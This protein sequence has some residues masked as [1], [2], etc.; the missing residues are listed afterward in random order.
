[1][2]V[3]VRA[4]DALAGPRM[5]ALRGLDDREVQHLRRVRR[6][7]RSDQLA[8]CLCNRPIAFVSCVLVDQAAR[9]EAWRMRVMSSLVLALAAAASVFPVWRRSWKRSP[10]RS[11]ARTARLHAVYKLARCI[12]WS[13]VSQNT[14]PSGPG[15][16][17][18][19]RWV[20]SSGI[21]ACGI[22]TRSSDFARGASSPGGGTRTHRHLRSSAADKGQRRRQGLHGH[23]SSSHL[24]PSGA[25]T[26]RCR[27]PRRGR[28]PPSRRRP[29]SLSGCCC[30]RV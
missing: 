18:R 14:S 6:G 20:S 5:R 19:A 23:R 17:R 12:G 1:M 2:P 4:V 8:E 22:A 21:S 28:A 25:K 30:A 29:R 15:A 24:S 7:G 13:R 11:A 16:A 10:S 9:G 26:G 3:L 27:V